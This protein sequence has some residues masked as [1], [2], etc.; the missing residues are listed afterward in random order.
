MRVVH[1]ARQ[2]RR[3]FG[4]FGAVLA[5]GATSPAIVATADEAD[6][7]A[8]VSKL[9]DVV[10]AGFPG[11]IL[12][13]EL[14]QAST[15]SGP[16]RY[17]VKLLTEQGVVL[18]LHYDA[19]TLDLTAIEGRDGGGRSA[20]RDEIGVED[21]REDDADRDDDGTPD[22]SG[23]GSADDGDDDGDRDDGDDDGDRDDGDRDDGGDD[24]GG[25][26]NSGPGGGGSDNSGSGG[27]GSGSGSSGS[28]GSDDD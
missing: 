6:S 10:E 5:L 21:E 23:P 7:L 2:S 27:G 1:R 13:I 4:P 14:G 19:R 12:M 11:R 18:R 17:D 3:W 28:G 20:G 25:S 9:I 24:D 22:N 26:D 15:P 8:P 16:A